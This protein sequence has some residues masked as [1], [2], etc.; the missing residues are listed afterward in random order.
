MYK[1]SVTTLEKFRRY[2]NEASAY[3][4][5]EA[6]IESIKGTFK[7]NDKT[8]FGG[9]YHKI[10]EGD[11]I[12][13]NKIV[14]ADNICFNLNQAKP[15]LQYR[16]NHPVVANEIPIEKVYSIAT[17]P[18]VLIKGKVDI[19]VGLNV[20]DVKCK[21]KYVDTREYTESCQWK[22]YLDM[23][24]ARNFF[25]DIFEVK[26]F[27][28]FVSPNMFYERFNSDERAPLIVSDEVEII[29]H[30]PLECVAYPGMLEEIQSIIVDFFDF[31][32]S[33]NLFKYLKQA[34][35]SDSIFN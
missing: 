12:K 28:G 9:A 15:A 23:L 18:D 7:G 34:E 25:Y 17:Y 30:D 11:F 19:I 26:G 32:E 20:R 10:I 24:Q 29:G 1:I 8:N 21:F 35:I 27:N 2:M 13:Q 33:R 14:I 22:F 31:V 6:L 16:F 5:E 4:T 3:D